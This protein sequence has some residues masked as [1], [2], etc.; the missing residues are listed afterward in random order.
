MSCNCLLMNST[1]DRHIVRPTARLEMNGPDL[2]MFCN[3]QHTKKTV[4]AG[5]TN[6]TT[7]RFDCP[8]CRDGSRSV[9]FTRAHR[10]VLIDYHMMYSCRRHLF[11]PNAFSVCILVSWASVCFWQQTTAA[12]AAN[13]SC[14]LCVNCSLAS[15]FL[16]SCLSQSVA[17][18]GALRLTRS[19]MP[20]V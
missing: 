13:S 9:R 14:S 2:L 10:L 8:C 15:T 3:A 6:Q 1:R 11:K 20:T 5:V 16:L 18:S 7:V 17:T 12:A 19:K 4:V